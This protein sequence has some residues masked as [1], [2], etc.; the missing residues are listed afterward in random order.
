MYY[1]AYAEAKIANPDCEIVTTGEKWNGEK[2]LVGS[3][4]A[5]TVE[6]FGDF[7]LG[8]VA[9]I[10]CNPADYCSSLKDFLNAGFK[11]DGGDKYIDDNGSVCEVRFRDVI[12]IAV[13]DRSDLYVLSAA[14][15]NGGCK[16]PAKVEQWSVHNNT[17]PLCEL[18]DEQV[19]KLVKHS[20]CVE[21]MNPNSGEWTATI[22]PMWNRAGVYRIKP[23]SER[24][25]FIENS[26][27]IMHSV[28]GG[29]L[30]NDITIGALYDS[31]LRYKDLTQHFGEN[32]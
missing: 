3:F 22:A 9:W 6:S 25:L 7:P 27:R 31:G 13:K 28:E 8:S 15:L 18:T 29:G 17:L 23:K 26:S 24:E 4:A 20:G 30:I 5:A 19:G 2:S 10:F 14:A 32:I 21:H 11:L 16:I 12:N 1:K